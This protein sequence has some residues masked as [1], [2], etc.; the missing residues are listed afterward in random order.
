MAIRKNLIAFKDLS[1]GGG[2]HQMTSP[3]HVSA[4]SAIYVYIFYTNLLYFVPKD[5]KLF[6]IRC[7]EECV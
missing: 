1:G 2:V 3:A 6:Q 4:L 5:N 7:P